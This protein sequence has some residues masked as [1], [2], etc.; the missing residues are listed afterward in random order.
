MYFQSVSQLK[1]YPFRKEEKSGILGKITR[2]ALLVLFSPILIGGFAI[3]AAQGGHKWE[4]K[5][6][7][8]NEILEELKMLETDPK[9]FWDALDTLT[10]PLKP[11]NYEKMRG[12]ILDVMVPPPGDDIVAIH[13]YREKILPFLDQ[14]IEKSKQEE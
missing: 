8:W 5:D 14:L 3:S 1:S 12:E 13:E 7:M 11:E 6:K 10:E 9:R 4:M 2:G